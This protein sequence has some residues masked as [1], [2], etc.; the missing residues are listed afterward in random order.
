MSDLFIGSSYR[1]NRPEAVNFKPV[2]RPGSS[3]SDAP[4]Q[5]GGH[6]QFIKSREKNLE[7][8][9]G[10]KHSHEKR[11]IEKEKEKLTHEK[12]RGEKGCFEKHTKEKNTLEKDRGE[13]GCFEKLGEKKN[14]KLTHEKDL[15][16]AI[17]PPES[18]GGKL[19]KDAEK[20]SVEK[21]NEKF[22]E[23][24]RVEK[25]FEKGNLEKMNVEKRSEKW[26]GEKHLEIEPHTQPTGIIPSERFFYK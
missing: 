2:S 26:I 10:E 20:M 19:E 1:P 24:T 15:E 7:K 9:F 5:V 14:E 3:P 11:S 13:K 18:K 12:D 4:N 21:R 23:K 6:D 8:L 17:W 22:D 25:C 16:K